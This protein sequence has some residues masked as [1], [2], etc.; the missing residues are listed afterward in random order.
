MRERSHSL[1]AWEC[2]TKP[3][4]LQPMQRIVPENNC[5]WKSPNWPPR[6]HLVS[7]YW[8][9]GHRQLRDWW[10]E[11]KGHPIKTLFFTSLTCQPLPFGFCLYNLLLHDLSSEHTTV[12]CQ[13][14]CFS[15]LEVA[16]RNENS[17]FASTDFIGLLLT[18]LI[19]I[20]WQS[21]M[22]FYGT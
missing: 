7:T 22:N 18:L 3:S 5:R 21:K 8:P 17:P 20:N 16:F 4:F 10:F 6:D 15:N 19:T 12:A 14:L 1:C 13:R 2:V 9:R 11:L